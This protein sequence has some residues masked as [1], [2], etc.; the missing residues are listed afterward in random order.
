V[1][2][3]FDRGG[4]GGDAAAPQ[5]AGGGGT[6][7]LKLARELSQRRRSGKPPDGVGGGGFGWHVTES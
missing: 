7:F 1:E 5:A 4:D 6:G 2:L 3:G